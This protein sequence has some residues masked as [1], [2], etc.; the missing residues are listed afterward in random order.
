MRVKLRESERGRTGRLLDLL[1]LRHGLLG[2]V[3]HAVALALDGADVL[4]LLLE[5]RLEAPHL[6]EEALADLGRELDVVGAVLRRVARAARRRGVERGRRRRGRRDRGVRGRR[7]EVGHRGP[8]AERQARRA[9]ANGRA[10]VRLGE[11][12]GVVEGR[13]AA[14]GGRADDLVQVLV[15]V[16]P[17]LELLLERAQALPGLLADLARLALVAA[18]AAAAAAA[19]AARGRRARRRLAVGEPGRDLGDVADAAL[20]LL[21]LREE[22]LAELAGELD[23]LGLGAQERLEAVQEGRLGEVGVVAVGVGAGEVR[24]EGRHAGRGARRARVVRIL[25]E[26]RVDR[27]GRRGWRLAVPGRHVGG[28]RG[29][30]RG[31]A[32]VVSTLEP[33]EQEPHAHECSSECGMLTARDAP[34]GLVVLPGWSYLGVDDVVQP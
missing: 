3:R 14:S 5:E 34:S 11:G 2:L 13:D 17:P 15:A 1:L 20:E 10:R 16:L 8:L 29:A 19:G 31:C 26:E 28:C 32:V 4:V 22:G 27:G 7:S 30:A 25:G 12:G 24:R 23:L 9:R 21:L 33:G 6:D 18:L